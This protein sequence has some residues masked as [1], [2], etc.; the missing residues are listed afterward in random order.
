MVTKTA[1]LPT[2]RGLP[3]VDSVL[4]AVTLP[5]PFKVVGNYDMRWAPRG[6]VYHRRY[7]VERGSFQGPITVNLADRQ[8][9]HL[10]GV[11]GPTITVPPG[12]SEFDYAVQLPPWME[13]GR[14]CRVCVMAVG[15]IKDADGSEHEV[16]FSS[17]AQNEQMV[18]VIEPGRLGVESDRTSL[19]AVPG[20]TLTIPLRVTRGRSLQGPA[21]LELLIAEHLRGIVAD[22]VAVPAD[23]SSAVFPIRFTADLRGPF[24]V[25]L[26]IRATVLEKGEPIVAETKVGLLPA[27]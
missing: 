16:S 23:Q 24:N 5:T 19:T 13:T 18:A 9:R 3:E 27:P 2:V 15:V 12:I 22:P 7:R 8:A 4:L 14:T 25:P 10:Q 1:T 20:K 17:T 6:T 26:V 11:I 21:K